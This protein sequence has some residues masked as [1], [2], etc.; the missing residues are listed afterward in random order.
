MLKTYFDRKYDGKLEE[1][2]EYTAPMLAIMV[3][4]YDALSPKMVM[5]EK[6]TS[7]EKLV[8]YRLPPEVHMLCGM[9]VSDLLHPTLS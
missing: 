5:G 4:A 7:R 9:A 3:A 6:P 2:D 1:Y 8:P